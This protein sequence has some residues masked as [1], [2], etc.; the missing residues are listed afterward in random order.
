MAAGGGD[1]LADRLPHHAFLSDGMGPTKRQTDSATEE[2]RKQRQKQVEREADAHLASWDKP[3]EDD[4]GFFKSCNWTKGA[5]KEL[6]QIGC[7][8][9]YA[10]EFR[11]LRGLL[12]LM[13]HKPEAGFIRPIFNLPV[14]WFEGLCEYDVRRVLGIW[15]NWLVSLADDLAENISFEKLFNERPDK[16]KGAFRSLSS[17]EFFQAEVEL[18]EEIPPISALGAPITLL[19][20]L[21]HE[22]VC[23]DG[24]ELIA[25]RIPWGALIEEA[26]GKQIERYRPENAMCK[27][28]RGRG[29][30]PQIMLRS[31]LKDL[32]VMRIWKRFPKAKD[33]RRRIREV[34]K[35]TTY[36]GCQT[37]VDAHEKAFRAGQDD[38]QTRNASS[39]MSAA[40]ARALSVFQS[41]FRGETPSNFMPT[42]VRIRRLTREKS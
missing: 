11:K 1:A 23:Y 40:C 14:F 35:F 41:F 22:R 17:R 3:Q 33:L 24:S 2:A 37:Y 30:R 26:I 10:R 36:K 29:K 8:W 28:P 39:E 31:Y 4:Y 34:A 12:W 38:P 32:S 21:E 13:K 9:E 5:S 15:F 25:F 18:V 20:T 19:G 27:A 42:N 6:L 16:L 7:I